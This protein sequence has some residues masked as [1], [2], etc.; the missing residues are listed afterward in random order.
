MFEHLIFSMI[1]DSKQ[2]SL[3]FDNNWYVNVHKV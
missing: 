3:L 2:Q 1:T